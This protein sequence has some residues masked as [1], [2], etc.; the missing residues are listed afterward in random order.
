MSFEVARISRVLRQVQHLARIVNHVR[1]LF[2]SLSALLVHGVL[3]SLRADHA[4]RGAGKIGDGPGFAKFGF[5]KDGIAVYPARAVGD[6]TQTDATAVGRD[7]RA[8]IVQKGGHEI[9]GGRRR[10]GADASRGGVVVGGPNDQRNAGGFV[11][12]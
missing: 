4:S 10:P 5:G 2:V 3:V 9:E 6:R 7:R 1:E 12:Q 11:I 8:R